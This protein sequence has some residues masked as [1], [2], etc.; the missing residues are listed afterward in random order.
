MKHSEAC[1]Q[2]D[3]VYEIGSGED[4][5]KCTCE[6]NKHL[7]LLINYQKWR[8]GCEETPM[9]N[10]KEIGDAL[11]YAIEF[12]ETHLTNSSV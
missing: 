1:P 9:P 12:L 5:P 8:R 2:K 11:D 7:H 6:D 3:F 4:I 10:P